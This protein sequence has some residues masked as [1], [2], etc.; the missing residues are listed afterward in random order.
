MANYAYEAERREL[1]KTSPWHSFAIPRKESDEHWCR[2]PLCD[3]T[4]W[5]GADRIHTRER[6]CPP[7]TGSSDLSHEV[8]EH[9]AKQH[10]APKAPLTRK[11]AEL[12]AKSNTQG[13]FV[14]LRKEGV[15]IEMHPDEALELFRNGVEWLVGSRESKIY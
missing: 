14:V 15:E 9:A 13:R 10:F 4:N 11:K 8:V 1:A 2:S 3:H 12:L 6:T 7:L 5:G